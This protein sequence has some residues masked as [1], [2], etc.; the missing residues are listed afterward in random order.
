MMCVEPSAALSEVVAVQ[1]VQK[2]SAAHVIVGPEGGWTVTEIAA[3]DESGA[4]LMTLGARTLRAD[5]VPIVALTA[6]LT[7]WREL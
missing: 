3:A 7:T 4:I 5:A 1:T 2:P 6:L